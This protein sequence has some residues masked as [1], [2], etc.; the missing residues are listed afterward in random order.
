[1]KIFLDKCKSWGRYTG[2]PNSIL[3]GAIGQ[4]AARNNVLKEAKTDGASH[5]KESDT[6]WA[7]GGVSGEAYKCE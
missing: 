5:F 7:D 6:S 3:G 2:Q 1:M 4:A